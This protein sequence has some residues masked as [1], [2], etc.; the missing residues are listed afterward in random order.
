M[1]VVVVVVW[2][3][4]RGLVRVVQTGKKKF[5]S[6]VGSQKSME[7]VILG[8]GGKIPMVPSILTEE[9]DGVRVGD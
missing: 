2:S 6:G 8:G 4:Y 5:S 1:L 7:E 3:G 9:V